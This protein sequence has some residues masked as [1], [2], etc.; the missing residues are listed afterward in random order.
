MVCCWAVNALYAMDTEPQKKCMRYDVWAGVKPTFSL[1]DK[2]EII[3]SDN[4]RYAEG[5]AILIQET[6]SGLNKE[7]YNEE[8]PITPLSTPL[9]NIEEYILK[10]YRPR[11]KYQYQQSEEYHKECVQHINRGLKFGAVLGFLAGG[12]VIGGITY[13]KMKK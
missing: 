2:K 8:E 1:S 7:P 11:I 13:W 6:A 4:K 5:L 3:W 12:I 10:A 9:S